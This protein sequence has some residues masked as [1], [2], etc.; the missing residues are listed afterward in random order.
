M[1]ANVALKSLM[2]VGAF[3]L[4]AGGALARPP[5]PPP[6]GPSWGHRPPP[7][8]PAPRYYR[9]HH[10]DWWTPLAIGGAIL[11]TGIYLDRHRTPEVIVVPQQ[12]AA[13]PAPSSYTW[14]W[15]ESERG[16]YP[17]VQT[18]PL[19][20]VPIQGSSPTQPPAPPR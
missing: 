12:P 4:L 19:G 11:G 16:Y 8:P 5:G 20:W 7:P 17:T 13:P 10:H 15:C 14:Y 1:K 3:A 6:G 9:Q 18:C 2:L